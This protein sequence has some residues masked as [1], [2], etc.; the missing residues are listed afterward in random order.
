MIVRLKA[1]FIT[2]PKQG[3][4]GW[5]ARYN[6]GDSWAYLG[7]PHPSASEALGAAAKVLAE[8]WPAAALVVVQ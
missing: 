2:N 6:A 1:K 4:S 5:L 3:W 8:R 7:G